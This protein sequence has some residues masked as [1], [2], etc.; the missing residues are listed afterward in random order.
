MK[1]FIDSAD[2]EEIRKLN[3]LGV[4]DGVT[5]NPTLIMKTGRKFEEA[6]KEIAAIVDGPISAEVVSEKAGEM[7]KEAIPLSKMHKNINIKVPITAEGLKAIKKLSGMGIKTNCTL[8]FSANQALLAAKAGATFAS[9]FVGRLD[10]KGE[11]GMDVVKDILQVF[12]NYGFKTEV[13]V[14]SVRNVDHVREAAMLGA[15]IATIPPKIIW[16][17]IGHDLTD[18]GIKRFLEDYEKA[19]EF[20][21]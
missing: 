16:E 11:R 12:R 13:I 1:I 8:V 9:P 10:D 5:T 4:I 18:V 19:R 7:V 20:K 6:V 2:V 3:E 14:A 15:D 17:M 21:K